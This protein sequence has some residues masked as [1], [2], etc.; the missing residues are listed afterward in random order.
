M[1]W[2]EPSIQGLARRPA[3]AGVGSGPV[4]FE[5][6]T[7]SGLRFGN[8]PAGLFPGNV[9]PNGLPRDDILPAGSPAAAAGLTV[10]LIGP[11]AGGAHEN[12]AMAAGTYRLVAS[13]PG[14]VCEW[15]DIAETFIFR[16]GDAT[17]D[18]IGVLGAPNEI[19]F[20]WN[21]G[22]DGQSIANDFNISNPLG[23]SCTPI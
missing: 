12:G 20:A 8:G 17:P 21:G 23:V 3:Y 19:L 22:V 2:A 15:T 18:V 1:V 7:V 10:T 9:P 14:C 5:V 16:R 6:P 11:L 13:L 4:A